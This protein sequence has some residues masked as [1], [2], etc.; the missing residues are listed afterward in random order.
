MWTIKRFDGEMRSCWDDMW[1][2]Y[3]PDMTD[4]VVRDKVWDKLN[5]PAKSLFM[6][7]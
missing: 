7:F 4:A 2:V 1:G 3:K 5:D 6:I